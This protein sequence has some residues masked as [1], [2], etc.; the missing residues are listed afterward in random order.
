MSIF[1]GLGAEPSYFT[2]PLTEP[3]VAGSM[4]VEAARTDSAEGFAD[5]LADSLKRSG[6]FLIEL[7][8]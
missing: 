2:A 1:E 6:P 4:G 7:L 3:T 5:L 8:I